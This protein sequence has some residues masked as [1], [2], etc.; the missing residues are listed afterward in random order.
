VLDPFCGSGTTLVQANEL[1]MHAIGID[2][3]SFNALISN[4]KTTKY[5]LVELFNEVRKITSA[6]R[7]FVSLSNTREFDS[8]LLNALT[9]FNNTYF[10]SPEYKIRIRSG[11]INESEYGPAKAREFEQIYKAL[12][13]MYNIEIRQT[14]GTGNF[15]AK[16][17]VK[18]IRQEI[19]LVRSLIEQIQDNDTRNILTVIISR[20]IRSCRATTHFDLATLKEPMLS[21]YYCHKHGKI[22]KPLFSILNWWIRYSED[23]IARL[24]QF[25]KLRTDTNQICLIGDSRTVDIFDE[26]EKY[27]PSLAQLAKKQKIKGIFSSPPYV[28]LID[29]HD[30]HAYAYDLFNFKRNDNLEIG[31]MALGQGE[32]ARSLYVESIS[33]SLINCKRFLTEDYDVFLVANDKFNLYPA[34][35]QNAGMRVVN[36]YKRPVLD[37]TE[38]DKGAY[39]EIIFHLKKV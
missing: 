25:D 3:S 13:L 5:K 10:P 24:S 11:Q 22:C 37:R 35:A 14:N 32:K 6:L 21:T 39:S 31:K 4:V 33:A 23:T 9:A 34:I 19:D 2:V 8:K 26:L 16:W 15:L 1:S 38:R 18:S 36:Q 20:T 28:G 17:Y 7:E 30:Q 27:K 29:Y 12:V